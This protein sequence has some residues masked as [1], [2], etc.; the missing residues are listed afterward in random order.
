MISKIVGCPKW[1][2]LKS[3]FDI[4]YKIFRIEYVGNIN[5]SITLKTNF[6]NLMIKKW[7]FNSNSTKTKKRPTRA[8]N[9]GNLN[10][11][12]CRIIQ[13]STD[14]EKKLCHVIIQS[15]ITTITT[16]IKRLA[17]EFLNE[18]EKVCR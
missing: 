4:M 13:T 9:Y 12:K 14:I 5:I 1:T 6:Q 17:V 18:R 16:K 8:F 2:K 3:S 7:I 11:F 10:H 15:I